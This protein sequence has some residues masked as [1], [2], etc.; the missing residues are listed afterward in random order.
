MR[1]LAK[2]ANALGRQL[3]A[4]TGSLLPFSPISD[5][6]TPYFSLAHSLLLPSGESRTNE[7]TQCLGTLGV[8]N[9]IAR[10]SVWHP[11]ESLSGQKSKNGVDLS[12][13]CECGHAT[14]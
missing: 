7:S 8:V 10:K 9:E 14:I 4:K 1:L 11:R 3:P 2:N 13:Y 5:S 12:K 6:E